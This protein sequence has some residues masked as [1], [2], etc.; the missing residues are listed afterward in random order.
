MDINTSY[1]YKHTSIEAE[2][3]ICNQSPQLD[4]SCMLLE[5]VDHRGSVFITPVNREENKY[6]FILPDCFNILTGFIMLNIDGSEYTIKSTVLFN[7][8]LCT[9]SKFIKNWLSKNRT[10]INDTNM[11]FHMAISLF[12]LI[13]FGSENYFIVAKELINEMINNQKHRTFIAKRLI[14]DCISMSEK[15][16]NEQSKQF[17]NQHFID[18]C[19]LAKKFGLGK[20]LLKLNKIY[21]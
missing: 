9:D 16:V 1:N 12:D 8:N 13:C 5:C 14:N 4:Y 19:H 3:D 7:E 10:E 11:R 18:C 15:V 20:E 6:K 21:Y 2:I 17:V